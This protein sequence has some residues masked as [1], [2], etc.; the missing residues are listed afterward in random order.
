[1]LFILLFGRFSELA[2]FRAATERT[3]RKTA[4]THKHNQSTLDVVLLAKLSAQHFLALFMTPMTFLAR[5]REPALPF[6]DTSKKTLPRRPQ[7]AAAYTMT[8]AAFVEELEQTHNRR[9]KSIFLRFISSRS[10]LRSTINFFTLPHHQQITR[11]NQQQKTRKKTPVI[12]L[13]LP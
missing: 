3:T 1:M 5:A 9:R 10:R 2:V 4:D 11:P 6:W 8:N 13:E 12:L 7:K